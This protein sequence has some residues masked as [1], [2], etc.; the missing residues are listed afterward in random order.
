MPKESAHGGCPNLF[1]VILVDITALSSDPLYSTTNFTFDVAQE[2][3]TDAATNPI[4]N[5]L[6]TG[7]QPIN[8]FSNTIH[9]PLVRAAF[10]QSAT[11]GHLLGNR[12]YSLC[13]CGID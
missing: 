4:A 1:V 9:P 5:L 13:V 6:I 8:T 2:Y 7:K 11:G 12:M 10:N 3:T